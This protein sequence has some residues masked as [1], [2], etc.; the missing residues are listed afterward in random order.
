MDAQSET[1]RLEVETPDDRVPWYR[2]RRAVFVALVILPTL[3]VFVYTALIASPRYESRA[4]FIIRGMERD[5]PQVGGLA[6]LVGAGAALDGAPRE[7]LSVRDYMLSLEAIGDLKRC[8]V[9]IEKFLYGTGADPLATLYHADRRAEGL[10]DYYQSMVDVDYD[11]GDG[12]SRL[13]VRA[14]TPREAQRLATALIALGEDQVNTFNRRA[15]AAGQQLARQELSDAETELAGIQGEL[16]R[17]RDL[18]GDLDPTVKGKASEEQ[19]ESTEAELTLERANLASMRHHLLPSSPLVQTAQGRVRALEGALTQMKAR[20]AGDSD[21]LTR[22]LSVFEKLQLRQQFA[23]KR[24]EA[25][26]TRLAEA[27]TEAERQRLFLVQV[28]NPNLPEKPVA[29]TPFKTTLEVFLAL[30]IAYAIGAL[31]LAGIR[32]HQAD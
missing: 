30:C 1:Y 28:V 20:L 16:T 13:S 4:E 10:R 9:D 21:A 29:P 15:I 7:A 3:I 32:E 8:G 14:Y 18:S 27:Q 26:R 25:A 31:L 2:T 12:I 19:L 23:A 11:T 22:R 24:Y 17:F 5:K 6:E